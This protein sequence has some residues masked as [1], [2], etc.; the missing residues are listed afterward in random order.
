MLFEKNTNSGK[1]K[2]YTGRI[3]KKIILNSP[4]IRRVEVEM[5]KELISKPASVVLPRELVQELANYLGARALIIG[6][7]GKV[8]QRLREYEEKLNS[9]L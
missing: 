6:P 4:P 8:G 2:T 5:E 1:G 9:Y 3:R 7:G